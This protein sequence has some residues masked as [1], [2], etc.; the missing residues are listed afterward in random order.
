MKK[1]KA[2]GALPKTGRIPMV[3]VKRGACRG[4]ESEYLRPSFLGREGKPIPDRFQ[5]C[6]VSDGEEVGQVNVG[7]YKF[8]PNQ[9]TILPDG[10]SF[11]VLGIDTARKRGGRVGTRLYEA[12]AKVACEEYGAPLSSDYKRSS[13]AQAFWEKQRAKGRARFV[14][15]NPDARERYSATGK[16]PDNADPNDFKKTS[17]DTLLG[18]FFL[19][20]PAPASLEGLPLR[21]RIPMALNGVSRFPGLKFKFSQMRI[22]DEDWGESGTVDL[23]RIF[24]FTA[25]GKQAGEVSVEMCHAGDYAPI[26]S[27][28]ITP[29]FRGKGLYPKMLSK[30]RDKLKKQGCAGLVSIG[31]LRST[32]DSTRSW[33]QFAVREPRVTEF[34]G[35]YYL[36]GL[37]LR[38]RIPMPTVRRAMKALGRK[39]KACK[40][41]PESLRLGMEVEREHRDVTRGGMAK[42]AQIA[43][44]HLCESNRYYTELMKLERKLKRR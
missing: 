44:A 41:T 32:P 36:D 26:Y 5:L 28:E 16:D 33:E 40:I 9:Q 15:T 25:D 18:Q 27:A 11:R 29:E 37:P 17:D 6:A 10:R 7:L 38:G 42:T 24:A 35:D 8:Y 12:A 21:G 2:M 4:F 39:V 30:M 3:T 20:C 31:R 34:R 23:R 13:Q 19:R 1:V 43:A 22:E 14:V